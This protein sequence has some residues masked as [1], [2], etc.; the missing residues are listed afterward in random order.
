MKP[1]DRLIVHAWFPIVLLMLTVTNRAFS[2]NA[3]NAA[4]VYYQALLLHPEAS[5]TPPYVV[6][7]KV[8]H[9]S[10]PDPTVRSYLDAS[11]ETIQMTMT[12]AEMSHSAWGVALTP[13]GTMPTSLANLTDQ[14]RRLVI[15]L[16]VDARTNIAD[17]EYHITI[18]RCLGIRR[19]ASHMAE[20]TSLWYPVS[21]QFQTSAFKCIQ[22]VLGHMSSDGDQLIWLQGQ[23]S[24]QGPPPLPGRTMEIALRDALEFLHRHPESIETWRNNALKQVETGADTSGWLKLADADLLEEA[25]GSY[26]RFMASANRVLGG[27][28]PYDQK[29]R[30]L[31]ELSEDLANHA[32]AG[33]PAGLV[34]F[35]VPDVSELYNAYVLRMAHYNAIRAAIEV[36][37]VMAGTGQFPDGLPDGLA[38]DPYSGLTFRYERTGDGFVLRCQGEDIAAG[39]IQEYSF[40]ENRGSY[41]HISHFGLCD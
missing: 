8:L 5:D 40:G 27:D 17:Q 24:V 25:K 23:L 35:L 22:S 36:Y 1:T 21:L 3:D 39:G 4:L 34:Q 26:D 28:M 18:E 30:G 20:E 33:D 38:K 12:A 11:L 32:T 2:H 7:E 29:Y 19:L 10:A 37:L 13:W 6:L 15:L 41:L 31:Q 14:L 9:G 16:D